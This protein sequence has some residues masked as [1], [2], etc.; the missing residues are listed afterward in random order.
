MEPTPELE[1]AVPRLNEIKSDVLQ[2]GL[3]KE[4]KGEKGNEELY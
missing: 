1:A 2:P 3:S 4:E